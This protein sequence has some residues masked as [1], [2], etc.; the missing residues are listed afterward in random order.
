[1]Q[2]QLDVREMF[3]I[4]GEQTVQLAIQRSVIKQLQARIAELEGTT[5]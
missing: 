4:I 3:V 2:P 1:M 5:N